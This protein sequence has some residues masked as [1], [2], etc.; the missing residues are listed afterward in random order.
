MTLLQH[1]Y[2]I[3][4]PVNLK[5]PQSKSEKGR[6][7]ER[8]VRDFLLSQ[9]YSV[10]ERFRDA[11]TEIDLLCEN[12]L[13]KDLVVV[14]CKAQKDAISTELINKIFTDVQLYNARNGWIFSL[15]ELGKEA[16]TRII[17]IN[18]MRSTELIK[19][20]SA[21]DLVRFL[22]DKSKVT[23]PNFKNKEN[24]FKEVYLCIKNENMIWCAIQKEKVSGKP[25]GIIGFDAQTGQPLAPSDAPDISDTDFPY[26]DLVWTTETDLRNAT[27]ES[28]QPVVEVIA[29]D[30]WSDY[31][32]SRPDDFVGRQSL[33]VEIK[34]FFEKVKN[35][36]T[37][38]R[39]FGI[40]GQSGWGKSSLTLKLQDELINDNVL[41]FPVDCRA[42][43]TSFYPDLVIEKCLQRASRKMLGNL[44]EF[45]TDFESNPFDNKDVSTLFDLARRNRFVMCVIFDQFEEIVHKSD[46]QAVFSRLRELSLAVDECQAPFVIG[47]S[48]KTDGTV[49]SDFPGYH[50]WHSL[51][52]RRRDFE[53]ERLTGTDAER[54]IS[55]AQKESKCSLQSNI[56]KF[57]IDN[58][59]GFPW[60]L[61]KLV[62]F[63]IWQQKT[64]KDFYS[65]SSLVPLEALFRSDIQELTESENRAV[66]FVAQNS[67]VEFGLATERYGDA[68]VRAL[69]D[70][71][72]VINT[73][74]QLNLY[75]DIFRNYILY[76]EVPNL[77]NTYIPAMTPRKIKSVIKIIMED[78]ELKY[79]KL[80]KKLGVSF[81]TA[82]N[83]IRDLVNFSLGEANRGAMCFYRQVDNPI[84]ATSRIKSFLNKH[85]IY[86]RAS[87][88]IHANDSASF[89]EIYK[90]AKDDYSFTPID[91]G[92]LNQYVRRILTYCVRFGLINRSGQEFRFG[93]PITNVITDELR[94][95]QI[96]ELELFRAAAPPEKV[97]SLLEKVKSGEIH[98][99]SQAE[100]LG[101][102]N[103]LTAASTLGVLEIERNKIIKTD[104]F[105]DCDDIDALVRE[106]LFSVEP[107]VG[108][109]SGCLEQSLSAEDLGNL[110]ADNFNLNWSVGSCRRHGSSYKRWSLW[111]KE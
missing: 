104:E 18:E 79:D 82:D 48:W 46:L 44:F 84:D 76:D 33:I 10:K 42:A 30:E 92:T 23:L 22:I 108:L 29:G 70:K 81:G 96:R 74:G 63:Y 34:D 13:S 86:S 77:P 60:L 26:T 101:L 17:K 55:L 107:F 39:L 49:G 94:S 98:N 32:P 99:K 35:D 85:S 61:K 36:E 1:K 38:S 8:L 87:D 93:S 9:S 106:K 5:S 89:S 3:I 37:K 2:K 102:R 40:K 65:G 15:S 43:K 6:V 103:S 105:R 64:N 62:R 97:I 90:A 11:G 28:I 20:F 21:D 12:E 58:Y 80:A 53:M 109:F 83:F 31:R 73:G 110:V 50:L 14:E 95:T 57:I 67:P 54:F 16:S 78:G 27:N 69:V 72:I 68:I 47:F 91:D 52:D 59:A 111:A 75:W 66:K 19:F 4:I 51:S 7:F 56:S 41:I 71:R 88:I 25:N 100:K 45:A 24:E